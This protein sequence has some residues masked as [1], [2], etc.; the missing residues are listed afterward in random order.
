M[1]ALKKIWKNASAEIQLASAVLSVLNLFIHFLSR[2]SCF[3]STLE[4]TDSTSHRDKREGLEGANDVKQDE[5]DRSQDC[6]TQDEP[7]S[8]SSEPCI[9][10]EKTSLK[11]LDDGTSIPGD[12]D[13]SHNGFKVSHTSTGDTTHR[14]TDKSK[15]TQSS[16]I[17]YFSNLFDLSLWRTPAICL[18]L[19][20]LWFTQIGN[21]LPF[22]MLPLRVEEIGGTKS[23]AAVLVAVLGAASVPARLFFGWFSDQPWISRKWIYSIAQSVAGLATLVA[24]FMPNY[25]LLVAYC[26]VLS[27]LIGEEGAGGDMPGNTETREL[28]WCQ[29]RQNEHHATS[30][31]SVKSLTVDGHFATWLLIGCRP[32][33][34]NTRKCC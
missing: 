12:Q 19:V 32:V 18:F 11:D 2:V 33:R 21:F 31:F 13:H 15:H 24:Y 29:L 5:A 17:R 22:M 28:S 8:E 34:I 20:S 26:V 30:R 3:Q 27:I 14:D 25:K 9:Q 16:V 23:Q 6:D 1:V 4:A 10:P 7:A